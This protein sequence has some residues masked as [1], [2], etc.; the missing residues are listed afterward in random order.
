MK[1]M[2]LSLMAVAGLFVVADAAAFG[3]CPRV[4]R[5]AAPCERPCAPKCGPSYVTDGCGQDVP[6][7]FEFEVVKRRV[8]AIQ[9]VSYTCPAQTCAGEEGARKV[10]EA[11][12]DYVATQHGSRMHVND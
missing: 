7:C 4:K 9:H 3:C 10:L 8:P 12:S 6:D 2:L 11:C 5:C 1:K